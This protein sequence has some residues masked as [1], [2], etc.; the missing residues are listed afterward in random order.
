M[1]IKMND[2]QKFPLKFN[3]KKHTYTL[4]KREFISVTTFISK[5]FEGF[6]VN[7]TAKFLAM[8]NRKRGVKGQGVRYY[9]KLW[10]SQTDLGTEVHKSIEA[11]IKNKGSTLKHVNNDAYVKACQAIGYIRHK[12]L[13]AKYLLPEVKVYSDDL[14]L[15]GT[16]DL[17]Y[18]DP[19]S[20][21]TWLFDWKTNKE[22]KTE[23]YKNKKG[24]LPPTSNVADCNFNKYTLQLNI[25]AYIL[26]RDYGL[27][28]TKIFLVHLQDDKWVEYPVKFYETTV[29]EMIEYE[30]KNFC[31]S[32][33]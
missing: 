6:D 14:S 25:Y 22:I 13:N 8:L 17:V 26:Q 30:N 24:V 20:G 28:V 21:E 27:K 31:N 29:K 23:A 7:K 11:V 12:G 5:F 3:E 2:L 33:S 18:R 9:K 1:V 10:K 19:E 15:A 32:N 4:G 16:I